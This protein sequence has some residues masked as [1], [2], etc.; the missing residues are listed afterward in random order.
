[1]RTFQALTPEQKT[2]L[3]E[4][5][6]HT[7]GHCHYLKEDRR[8]GCPGLGAGTLNPRLGVGTS[9][10][11]WGLSLGHLEV[12]LSASQMAVKSDLFLSRGKVTSSVVKR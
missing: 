8:S 6:G 5:A 2:G 9:F 4:E 1:M 11:S 7:H 3:G 12:S 10:K